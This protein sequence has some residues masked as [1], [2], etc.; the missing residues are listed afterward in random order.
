M[1]PPRV[2]PGSELGKWPSVR[3]RSLR[4]FSSTSPFTPDSQRHVRFSS[5]TS[6]IRS[7][8]LMS[9]TSSPARGASAPQTPV[10]PPTGVPAPPLAP[11]QRRI[12]V[13]CSRPDGLATS[14]R[15][16]RTPARSSMIASGHVSRTGRSSSAAGPTI[17]SNSDHIFGFVF[18]PHFW[19]RVP[20]SYL[21]LCCEA[22]GQ[23]AREDRN[24][25]SARP[26]VVVTAQHRAGRV[27]VRVGDPPFPI[28][29]AQLL[30]G[31]DS[32][33]QLLGGVEVLEVLETSAHACDSL[34]SVK[35]PELQQRLRGQ[36]PSGQPSADVVPGR[37]HE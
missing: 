16:G 34:F 7:K 10:P 31:R 29:R 23:P 33:A 22:T 2:V 28:Q 21:L 24:A 15:G 35:H 4:C 17:L 6:K 12:A 30:V 19:F 8:A 37:E 3:P 13:T 20:L 9:R 25:E 5:S 1:S 18:R 14:T 11:A 32:A 27:Q 26:A 36:A